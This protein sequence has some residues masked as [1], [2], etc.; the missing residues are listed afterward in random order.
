MSR[1]VARPEGASPRPATRTRLTAA[2]ASALLLGAALVTTV[3]A[4]AQADSAT[5][6]PDFDAACVALDTSVPTGIENGLA[7]ANGTDNRLNT[8]VGGNLTVG[9]ATSEMEGL[10]VVGGTMNVT[11]PGW[12]GVGTVGAGSLVSPAATKDVLLVGGDLTGQQS[13]DLGDGKGRIGGS[14]ASMFPAWFTDYADNLGVSAL[15]TDNYSPAYSFATFAPTIATY[16]AELA[17]TGTLGSTSAT[18]GVITLDGTNLPG[19]L[20]FEVTAAQLAAA[21]AVEMVNLASTQPVVITV[22]G[23]DPLTLDS[24]PVRVT[25]TDVPATHVLPGGTVPWELNQY[26]YA[27]YTSRVM[28]NFTEATDITLTS[29]DQWAGS[30]LAPYADVVASQSI[31]GRIYVGGDFTFDGAGNE[32]HAF[33][34]DGCAT[35]AAVPATGTFT[36][37][38]AVT[39][40]EASAVPGTTEFAV[41]YTVNGTAAATDLTVLANGTVVNGPTLSAGDVVVFTEKTPPAVAGVAWTGATITVNGTTTNTLV[42]GDGET[43]T[44]V[45]TN[46]ASTP[47]VTPVTYAI[48]DLVWVDLDRDGQQD[49]GE[50]A[51]PDVLVRL[52]NGDG[53]PYQV[54]GADVTTTTNTQGRYLFDLLPAGDYRVQ[55][56]LTPTQAALYGYTDV[57]RPGADTNSDATPQATVSLG[58][59]GVIT[60]G[61]GNTALQTSGYTAL[62]VLATGGVDATWDAGVAYLQGSVALSKTVVGPVGTAATFDFAWTA[63]PATGVTLTLEQTSGTISVAGD[64]VAVTLPVDFPVGTTVSFAETAAPAFTGWSGPSVTSV[65][66]TGVS[67]AVTDGGTATVAVTNTYAMDPHVSVGDL[68]WIDTDG[69]GIQTGSDQGIPGVTLRITQTNGTPVRTIFGALVADQVTDPSGHFAFTYLPVLPAGEHY[70]VTVDTVASATAL[71]PYLPT[72]AGATGREV[73]SSTWT[74]ESIDLTVDGA[75]DGSLD[76]GFVL[77]APTGGDPLASTGA[78]GV[79]G[80]LAGAAALVAAGLVM[81]GVRRRLA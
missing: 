33:A 58:R 18:G 41:G 43:A 13:I 46:T 67:A 62:P 4:P 22:T 31:N 68:V 53:T 23:S 24:L 64:G 3:T 36:I 14:A 29:G 77:A 56:E 44:V 5:D 16:S 47:V 27:G 52:L 32:V 34:W 38:K 50:A 72:L 9:A 80:L 74:A 61:P 37:A 81:V 30:I 40:D 60:L 63:T 7:R 70:T 71:S 76:F 35:A 45:V 10:T 25:Y 28:W 66:A 54:G 48:G 57:L 21:D 73:D 2:T 26:E 19:Q 42:V 12:F 15:T 49:V 55:F 1:V 8:Y 17:A 65:P 75:H 6:F 11:K 20:R 59:S 39:G 69:N 79:A 51:L 78:D